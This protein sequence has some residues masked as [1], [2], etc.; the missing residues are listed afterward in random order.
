MTRDEVKDQIFKSYI[1]IRKGLAG[2]AL[3]FPIG[4]LFMGAWHGI[5]PQNSMSAYYFAQM[6]GENTQYVFPMRAWFVGILW[7]IGAFLVLYKGFSV[8]ENRFLNM[9]GLAAICVAMFPMHVPKEC[10]SCGS[11]AWAWVHFGAAGILFLCM[12]IV[13]WACADETL[14]TLPDAVRELYQ[15]RYT[16]LAAAMTLAP[17][18]VYLLIWMIWIGQEKHPGL[19]WAEMTGVVIFALYWGLKS[20]ELETLKTQEMKI[21]GTGLPG[22]KVARGEKPTDE[23]IP[24]PKNFWEKVNKKADAARRRT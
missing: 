20:Y 22:S 2:L 1:R 19:F 24:V 13:A 23:D 16:S 12:S 15:R 18:A 11:N 10:A 5:Y 7:A 4:L 14:A 21:S 3:L 17:V 8:T 9:A 6:P